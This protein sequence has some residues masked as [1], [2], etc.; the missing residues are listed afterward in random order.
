[1]FHRGNAYYFRWRVP[2]DLRPIL[3]MTELKQ[4]LFTSNPHQHYD[5][6]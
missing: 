2:D 5:H 4:S 3:G 6:T 1:M